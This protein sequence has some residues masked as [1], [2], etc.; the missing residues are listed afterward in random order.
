MHGHGFGPVRRVV[1][2]GVAQKGMPPWKQTFSRDDL[3]AV[4]LYVSSTGGGK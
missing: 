1:A 3:D 2:E 4:V